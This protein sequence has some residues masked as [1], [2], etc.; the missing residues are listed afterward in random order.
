MSNKSNC[1]TLLSFPWYKIIRAYKLRRKRKKILSINKQEQYN[2]IY[3]LDWTYGK[4][5]Y[6]VKLGQRCNVQP[7][8][9]SQEVKTTQ[10]WYTRKA[11]LH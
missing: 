6:T 4:L 2:I 11:E 5:T 9:G 3:L 1:Q 7:N 10:Q 8:I